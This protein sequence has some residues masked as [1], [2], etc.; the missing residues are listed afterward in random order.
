MKKN[1]TTR[2]T[3]RHATCVYFILGVLL[4]GVVDFG[5]A[6][7]FR[8]AYFQTYGPTL[9]LFYVG[10]PLVFTVLIFRWQWSERRLSVATLAAIFLIEV[11]F[12]GNP[13]LMTFPALLFGIPVAVA[14]YAPL[15]CFPLWFVRGQ[16]G[17]HKP[18][19]VGLTLVVIIIMALT[20]F[21]NSGA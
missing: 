18:L 6:G 21:G 1:E 19:V 4:W 13:L 20:T 3:V 9:L 10:Y 17:Q 7:G 5:T 8:I 14:V 15:T 12:T 2:D 11:V 16:M